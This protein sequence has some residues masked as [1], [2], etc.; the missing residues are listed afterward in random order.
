MRSKTDKCKN[1]K[2]FE[3]IDDED[4]NDRCRRYPPKIIGKHGGF[5]F[6][7]TKEDWVCGEF[8]PISPETRDWL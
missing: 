8:T 1:C 4:S 5:D 6:T 2:Y 7:P 3:K